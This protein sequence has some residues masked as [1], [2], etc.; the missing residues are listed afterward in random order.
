MSILMTLRIA[1]KALGRNKMRTAENF[2]R[3]ISP[4]A[5]LFESVELPSSVAD[6]TENYR[7][8]SEFVRTI[9]SRTGA[10]DEKAVPRLLRGATRLEVAQLLRRFV[11]PQ[12]AILFQPDAIADLL[13]RL[14][15]DT[16]NDW[17]VAI[18]FGDGASTEIGGVGIR[19]QARAM[20]FDESQGAL[21]VS[22]RNRRVGSRGAVKAG[23]TPE[24]IASAEAAAWKSAEAEAA[25]DGKPA[26]TKV[27]VGDKAYSLFRSRPLLLLHVLEGKP[28]DGAKPLP[29]PPHAPLV[30]LGLSFPELG[31]DSEARRVEYKINIVKARELYSLP[32]GDADDEDAGEEE[33]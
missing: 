26:P 13:E 17:D 7:R 8:V 33:P 19:R 31:D 20:R 23:M 16:L 5:T 10:G 1:F 24:Q 22:G 18:P 27:N 32:G 12:P 29:I 14:R 28:E 11:V 25:R 30:A 15:G 6:L 21:V 4:S 2:I 9:A 3:I